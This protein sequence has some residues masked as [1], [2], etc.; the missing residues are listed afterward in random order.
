MVRIGIDLGGTKI[1]AVALD[2]SGRVLARE[3]IAT[4]QND[5]RATVMAIGALVER[6]EQGLGCR[7]RVGI[8]T[9]GAPSA[10]DGRMKNANSTCLNGQ[11]L[12]A[13]LEAALGRPVRLANDANCFAVSEA[14]DGAARG[15]RVVFGVILGTGVGGGVVVDG[16]PL[17]GANAIAGEWGHNPLADAAPGIP[18]YCGRV[19]CVETWLSGPGMAADHVRHGG[20]A[21]DAATI[22]ARAEAGDAACEATLQRYEARLGRALATVINIVDPDVIVLGGGLSKLSRLYENVPRRW[23][24]HVFSDT[25]AT[26]LVPPMHGDSSGVRGAAWLWPLEGSE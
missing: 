5:Y 17:A 21:L 7:A 24:A 26:R 23:A 18:C 8:G 3:R 4:P 22:A 11:P 12:H 6:I 13:D 10:V 25:I 2:A 20:A 1:E 19:G 15:A 9:P 14:T 16:R